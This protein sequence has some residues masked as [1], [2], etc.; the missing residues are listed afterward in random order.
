MEVVV[1]IKIQS[2]QPVA[3]I[4]GEIDREFGRCEKIFKK[5]FDL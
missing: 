4:S 2:I 1:L 3:T 5:V